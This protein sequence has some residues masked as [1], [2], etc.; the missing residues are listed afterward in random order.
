MGHAYLYWQEY[1]R[2]IKYFKKLRAVSKM[3]SDLE[4]TMYSFK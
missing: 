4:T 2:A 3:S 1:P